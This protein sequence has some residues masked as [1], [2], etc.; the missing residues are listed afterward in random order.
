[1]PSGNQQA[2]QLAERGTLLKTSNGDQRFWCREVRKRNQSEHQT[3]ILTTHLGFTL[4]FIGTYMFS[5]WSQK[6]LFKYMMEHFAID[7]LVSYEK[8][9]IDETKS[10]VNPAWRTLDNSIKTLNGKLT[11]IK[12][13]F[14]SYPLTNV[15]DL[16]KK[17]IK[18]HTESSFA[19]S[20]RGMRTFILIRRTKPSMCH[21]IDL[22]N[23]KVIRSWNYFAR[24]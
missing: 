21:C 5:R 16:T 9:E 3:S 7:T 17:Q 22:L 2:M 13:K 18:S 20:I 6:N 23:G 8:Q 14:A 19:R 15:E 11:R 4:T 10:F 24:K 1:M 12:A